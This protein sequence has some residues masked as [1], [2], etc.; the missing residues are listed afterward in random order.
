MLHT[1]IIRNVRFTTNFRNGQEWFFF[2]KVAKNNITYSF[3]INTKVIEY[4]PDGLT[5]KSINSIDKL[6]SY[7]LKIEVLKDIVDC[8][9][10]S[11][12]KLNYVRELIKFNKY[13]KAKIILQEIFK[14]QFINLKF[15]TNYLKVVFK[16]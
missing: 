11:R 10:L 6:K 2:C 14:Y 12:Q 4:L 16:R 13:K 7:E 1:S 15:Y 8:N 5:K 3:D 9:R